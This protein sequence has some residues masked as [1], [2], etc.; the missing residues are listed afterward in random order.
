MH[1]STISGV[2]A[3]Y[4][5]G[6][7]CCQQLPSPTGIMTGGPESYAQFGYKYAAMLVI[8]Q[9]GCKFLGGSRYKTSEEMRD[10]LQHMQAAL[11]PYA[12][13]GLCM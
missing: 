11:R 4:T 3:I 1:S 5:S 6:H 9:R 10:H 2:P 7:G 13:L 8:E 12:T